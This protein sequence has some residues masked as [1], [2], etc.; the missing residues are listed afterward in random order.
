MFEGKLSA[1]Q[2]AFEKKITEKF[3][4]VQL[5]AEM[6]NKR[7]VQLE[8]ELQEEKDKT[9]KFCE[10]LQTTTVAGLEELKNMIE[11]EKVNRLEKEAQILKKV[12]EDFTKVN[13][14]FDASKKATEGALN[15]LKQELKKKEVDTSKSDQL[16]RQQAMQDIENLK[17]LL[18]NEMEDR[19]HT[20]EQMSQSIDQIVGQIHESLKLVSK[21]N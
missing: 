4:Q 17:I 14:R 18:K 11:S 10:T 12:S 3:S 13:E 9:K 7:I 19:Q 15:T 1:I 21:G 2:E 20:E 16:F 6:L 5:S 8:K